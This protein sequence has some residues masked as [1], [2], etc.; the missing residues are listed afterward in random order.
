MR[1][2][3][4]MALATD[5]ANSDPP[6]RE[7]R[8]RRTLAMLGLRGSKVGRTIIALNLIGLFILVAGALAFN[9]VRQSLLDAQR[10]SLTTQ[11]KVLVSLIDAIATTGDP[12]TMSAPDARE[13]LLKTFPRGANLRARIFD[14]QG[15]LIADS[16]Y[17]S[18]TVERY[19]LPDLRGPGGI[20]SLD[21]RVDDPKASAEANK[22]ARQ[23]LDGEVRR[24][25]TGDIVAHI[26]VSATGERVSSV[27]LP[28]QHV[29]AV[30]GTLTLQ[31]SDVNAIVNRQRLALLPFILIALLVTTVS[32]LLLNALVAE[33]VRRLAREADRVRMSR[34]RSISLPEVSRRDDEL[35]DLSR[36]LESMT[37]AQS[38]RMDAID[39]FAADVAHEIRNPLTSIRSAVE[40]LDL[41]DAPAAKARLTAILKQDVGR[42]DRLITDI[43]NAS[44]L[45][46]EL[47]R[48]RPK[49]VDLHHL[50]AEM[51]AFYSPTP[52]VTLDAPPGPINILG[53]EGPLGQ[54]FRNL[55]DNARSFTGPEGAVRVGLISNNAQA[56]ITIED[57]GPGIPHENL[58]TVF[59][60]FYT[61]RPRN[62]D[63]AA[64][65]T[66]VGN[67]GLGLSIARE[68]VIAHGGRV[69]AEN[70]LDATG[71]ILGARF[72]VVLPV[73]GAKGP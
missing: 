46:A 71:Q 1:S 11:G 26:R 30:I 24:A 58:E 28:I 25:L 53:R 41:V 14:A 54:V 73:K 62:P 29:R 33:P 8:V 59:Q 55:I 36:A 9:E 37:A 32:S 48:D 49:A 66:S 31:T 42:L 63:N 72:T 57:N 40:T 47:S 38:A 45:D 65:V 67:S 51:L 69:W 68:I 10:D 35:G 64:R 34:V 20:F 5:T 44:R 12:P 70:R 52:P 27:S 39:R 50:L 7:G 21:H 19:E 23:A 16:Y 17:V 2:K 22:R 56:S 4:S 13:F 18:D 15:E 60:R 43:S 6:E 3:P 61:S